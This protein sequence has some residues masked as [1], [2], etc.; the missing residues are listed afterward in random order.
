LARGRRRGR[1]IRSRHKRGSLAVM[2]PD[3]KTFMKLRTVLTVI[4]LIFGYKTRG[5]ESTNNNGQRFV[6]RDV[7]SI[8]PTTNPLFILMTGNGPIQFPENER[9]RRKIFKHFNL[10]WISKVE[11]LKGDSATAIYGSRGQHG[12]IIVN[13]KA[14]MNDKLPRRLKKLIATE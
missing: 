4:I 13:L 1:E 3:K 6:I 9:L 14:E 11:V 5:Q 10:D 12:V 7:A 2:A 8:T